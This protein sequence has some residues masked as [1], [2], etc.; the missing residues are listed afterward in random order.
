MLIITTEKKKTLIF[1]SK[2]N[3]YLSRKC[4]WRCLLQ[5]VSHFF[6]LRCVNVWLKKDQYAL[7][8][9][10]MTIR[11]H[12]G[13]RTHMD[14]RITSHQGMR[15]LPWNSLQN[16]WHAFAAFYLRTMKYCT[17]LDIDTVACDCDNVIACAIFL[18]KKMAIFQCFGKE[19]PS[20]YYPDDDLWYPDKIPSDLFSPK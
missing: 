10:I 13:D 5:N 9:I 15:S 8:P 20:L 1:E 4:I 17:C 19:E 7:I 12:T 14:P 11:P 3:I 2:C 6:M 18:I 16:Y